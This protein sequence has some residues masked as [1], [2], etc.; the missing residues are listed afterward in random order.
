MQSLKDIYQKRHNRIVDIVHSKIECANA[1]HK[2]TLKD[3]LL[4]PT[5]FHSTNN[6]N[7]FIT[8][9]TRPDI[10][11]IDNNNKHVIITEI[12]VPYDG[13][14]SKTFQSKFD[15]Y[16]PL[17]LEINALKGTELKLWFC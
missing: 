12:A 10:V 9:N 11:S 16:F 14:I 8:N 5:V 7:T 3:K 17:S 4:T 15:K 13:H 2:R 1:G 6:N